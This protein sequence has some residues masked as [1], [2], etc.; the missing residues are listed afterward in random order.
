MTVHQPDDES[1]SHC[2]GGGTD[3]SGAL[4][5]LHLYLDGEL[6]DADLA[7][8]RQHLA[9]CYPCADRATFEE[10]LRALVRDRC[11]ESAPPQLLDRI[12]LRLDEVG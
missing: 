5:D 6:P 7:T 1:L 12:R 10:Q 9:A 2:S 3:C 4:H 8:I 11:A